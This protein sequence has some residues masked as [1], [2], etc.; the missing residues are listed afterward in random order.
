M[1]DRGSAVGAMQ[2]KQNERED[3]ESETI[4]PAL[5]KI[6]YSNKYVEMIN[7]EYFKISMIMILESI[8]DV[9]IC[10]QYPTL[11]YSIHIYCFVLGLCP[12]LL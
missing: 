9:C 6:Q 7:S 8:E 4:S 3:R 1:P 5:V 10:L 12:L 11:Y 2:H